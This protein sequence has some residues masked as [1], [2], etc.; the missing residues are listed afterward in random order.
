M[1]TILL[2]ILLLLGCFPMV[3]AENEKIVSVK[4]TCKDGLPD[5]AMRY[6]AQDS[7]G[8]MI[9][10]WLTG[11]C[12]YDGYNFV[13]LGDSEFRD[14]EKRYMSRPAIRPA[15]HTD[16]LG[17]PVEVDYG[18]GEIRYTDRLTGKLYTVTGAFD[19][20]MVKL[21]NNVKVTVLTDRRGLVWM[22]VNGNGIFILDK[23]S[24]ELRHI[25]A[26]NPERLIDSDYVVC[27]REDRL[28][29]IWVS[30]D[31]YGVAILS[32][33]RTPY[34]VVQPVPGSE[35]ERQRSVRLLKRLAD[36]RIVAADDYGSVYFYDE[37]MSA[38]SSYIKNGQEN[39]ISAEVDASGRLWLGSRTKGVVLPDTILGEGRIDCIFR[40]RE[41]RMWICGLDGVVAMYECMAGG[42]MKKTDYFSDIEQL[43]PRAVVEDI[44]EGMMWLA[45][46]KGLF[47]FN[48]KGNGYERLL[49]CPVLSLCDDGNGGVWCGTQ[50]YGIVHVSLRDGVYDTVG[51]TVNDG[52]THNTVNSV[53]ADGEGN[54]L[55][56]T[57]DGIS[58]YSHEN[59]RWR[60][61]NVHDSTLGNYCNEKCVVALDDGR[62]AFGTLDGIVLVDSGAMSVRNNLP[63]LPIAMTGIEINGVPVDRGYLAQICENKKLVVEHGR[64]S[65]TLKISDFGFNIAGKSLYSFMLEGYDRSRGPWTDMNFVTYPNLP[66]G[67]YKLKV[68]SNAGNGNPFILDVVVKQSPWVTPW[69]IAVYV[70]LALVV[71]GVIGHYVREK[72]LLRRSLA[73][74]KRLTEFKIKFF[75]DISHEFKL[76]LTLI[77]ASMHRVKTQIGMTGGMRYRIGRMEHN[78]NRM[79]R[80][81]NQIMEFKR[82]EDDKLRL[83]LQPT[84]IVPFLKNVYSEF[85]DYAKRKGVNLSYYSELKDVVV[86]VD[87][88]VLDKIVYNLLSNALRYTP[89]G[90]SVILAV[91]ME[92]DEL[93]IMVSD[94]GMGVP[95]ALKDRLFERYA[96]SR[97]EP[98]STGIGLSFT[99]EL[100]IA[101]HGVIAYRKNIPRGSVFE[102]RIPVGE[103]E[104]DE[105]DY[106]EESPVC[107]TSEGDVMEPVPVTIS[108]ILP[109]RA[110]NPH[111]LLFVEY[112]EDEMALGGTVASELKRTFDVRRCGFDKVRDF[113]V[114]EQFDLIVCYG[115]SVSDIRSIRKV[116]GVE[117][118]PL[119]LLADRDKIERSE[120]LMAGAD[121]VI[122]TPFGIQFLVSQ[123]IALINR[124]RLVAQKSQSGAELMTDFPIPV[125]SEAD[126]LFVDRLDIFINSHPDASVEDVCEHFGFSRASLTRKVNNVTGCSSKEY[127]TRKKMDIARGWINDGVYIGEVA[128]RLGFSSPQNFATSFKR[129]F[130]KSPS[131]YRTTMIP[132]Q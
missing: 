43:S 116:D 76:S 107:M 94:T 40:D 89:E 119:L 108:D 120:A 7:V 64:N 99:N 121:V 8:N 124:C 41:N 54:I 46:G 106:L 29:N 39:F 18:K 80:L 69:A 35:I 20:K 86:D 92:G 110:I 28:G 33:I 63:V 91:R 109:V 47:R 100:V 57:N 62:Y 51:Y 75:T 27:M 13:V 72:A 2:T 130:G 38:L 22:S 25:S 95:E 81:V 113:C 90:N 61:L 53:I 14:L 82:L 84:E 122:V 83:S 117:A 126:R 49:E 67:K 45:A 74:E 19:N 103:G 111:K 56:G 129:Y 30:Q 112:D 50:G 55:A 65:L 36:G 12:V 44:D 5:N 4:L 78:V 34:S 10:I 79:T 24:G 85:Q 15:V 21:S 17:N 88:G 73:F 32:V 6:I 128:A 101:H 66:P 132:E 70:A 98:D 59:D 118:L 93:V 11:A 114:N 58:I 77:M 115:A 37:S 71:I 127:I 26:H 104:Y 60:S 48:V 102:V 52:I 31:K 105:S 125:M 97:H 23:A 16:N 87:R 42:E 131:Q 123:C 3:H 96:A 68:W 1:K 9:F